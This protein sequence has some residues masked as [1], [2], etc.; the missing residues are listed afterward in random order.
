V[1]VYLMT[2]DEPTSVRPR[3]HQWWGDRVPWFDV[4]DDLRRVADGH[5]PHPDRRG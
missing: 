4:R 3:V 1:S 2:L 5:L